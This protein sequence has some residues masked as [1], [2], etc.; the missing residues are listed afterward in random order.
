M[1]LKKESKGYKNI[2][3]SDLDKIYPEFQTDLEKTAMW[4]MLK[5]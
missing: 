2:P 1:F 5:M 3:K 4:A